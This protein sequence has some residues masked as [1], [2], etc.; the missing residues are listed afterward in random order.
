VWRRGRFVDG[1]VVPGV[2]WVTQA[3]AGAFPGTA[4]VDP[5][6]AER[7]PRIGGGTLNQL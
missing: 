5:E 1:L 2:Y 6:F 7:M 3:L 4:L